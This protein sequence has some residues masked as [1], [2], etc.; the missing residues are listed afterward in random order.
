MLHGA[1]VTAS[2]YLTQAWTRP[3]SKP[4]FQLSSA[5]PH[6]GE[7]TT[8][9]HEDKIKCLLLRLENNL[10]CG[11]VTEEIW[12]IQYPYWSASKIWFCQGWYSVIMFWNSCGGYWPPSTI[13]I[14]WSLCHTVVKYLTIISTFGCPWLCDYQAWFFS[15]CGDSVMYLISLNKLIFCVKNKRVSMFLFTT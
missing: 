13:L 5:E 2:G 9:T 3:N 4:K 10:L 7:Q 8:L 6:Q 14:S 12:L 1:I 11:I 15:L